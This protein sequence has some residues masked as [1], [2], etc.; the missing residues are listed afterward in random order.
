MHRQPRIQRYEN[1]S[2]PEAG[3]LDFQ[4][5]GGVGSQ[6]SHA[7]AALDA[8]CSQMRRQ[9]VDALVECA[10]SQAALRREI[11]QRRLVAAHL[12]VMGDPVEIGE[13]HGRPPGLRELVRGAS[14]ATIQTGGRA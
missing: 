6:H 1:C 3:E 13:T 10:V 12:G 7:L 9:P 5:V 11:D 2:Q 4:D 14:G 8:Q